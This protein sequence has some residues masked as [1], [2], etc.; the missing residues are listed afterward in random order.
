MNIIIENNGSNAIEVLEYEPARPVVNDTLTK[1]NIYPDGVEYHTLRKQNHIQKSRLMLDGNTKGEMPIFLDNCW[2]VWI[3]IEEYAY[4]NKSDL[5]P[6]NDL[7]D[8][9]V[10]IKSDPVKL[11]TYLY[12]KREFSALEGFL[13]PVSLDG[14]SHFQPIEF[15][16]HPQG[17][18]L[19]IPMLNEKPPEPEDV[20]APVW[21]WITR[22]LY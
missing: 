14:D 1:T 21:L 5:M 18:N 20:N 3:K 6:N 13:E 7:A 15:S 9:S 16:R 17:I 4:R 11:T 2:W 19:S 12:K 10:I 22:G 8:H